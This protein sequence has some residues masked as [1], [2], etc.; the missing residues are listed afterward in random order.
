MAKMAKKIIT[1]KPT[2]TES[3]RGTVVQVTGAVVDVQ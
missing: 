3:K 1:K 2:T